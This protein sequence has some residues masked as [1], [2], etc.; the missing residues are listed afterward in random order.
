MAALKNV[1]LL[2]EG[3]DD[4]YEGFVDFQTDVC[5]D[6]YSFKVH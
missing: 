6:T 1:H 4:I 2:T 3:E 5:V